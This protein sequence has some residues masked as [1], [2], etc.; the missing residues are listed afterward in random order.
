M[1]QVFIDD[2]FTDT[3]HY[4]DVHQNFRESDLRASYHVMSGFQVSEHNI[5]IE[6]RVG[7]EKDRYSEKADAT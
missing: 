7:P 1:Y 2:L 5:S 4:K 3:V 6:A